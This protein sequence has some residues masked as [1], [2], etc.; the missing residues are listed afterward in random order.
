M[1]DDDRLVAALHSAGM[2][3]SL[4]LAAE[5]GRRRLA[6]AVPALETLC[7]RF[8]GFGFDRVVPEQAAALD[9]LAMI[10]GPDATRAITR[11]IAKSVVQG[12]GLQKAVAT[13]AR[14]GAKLPAGLVLGL[15]R[16]DDRQ[17]R[18][19]A[20]R[21][22]RSWPEAIPLLLDLLDDLHSDVRMAAAS[23]LG[24][25]GRCEARSLLAGYLREQ[26]SAELIDAIAPVA[27]E[28]GII[29]LGR[30]ARTMAGLSEA[31]LNA[32]DAI[33]H[34]RAERIAIAIRENLVKFN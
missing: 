30:I 18:A 21:C 29:L 12:P 23:A 34:P 7:R 19:D 24:R 16:H 10:G 28:D 1:L 33:D 13:A 11:L 31:A 15:L 14:L 8:A 2:H 9:A 27:D 22:A 32:L 6:A 25:M 4:E 17:I 20:C 3:D 26:P 5:A